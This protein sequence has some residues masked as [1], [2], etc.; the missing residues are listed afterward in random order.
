[1]FI[2]LNRKKAYKSLEIACIRFEQKRTEEKNRKK[3]KARKWK[4]VDVL[5]EW[6][7][8]EKEWLKKYE[9][10][11]K[12]NGKIWK[13]IK[14]ENIIVYINIKIK[15]GSWKNLKEKRKEIK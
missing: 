5:S 14:D 6:M 3:R 15:V 4:N 1:M 8:E 2:I 7:T 12:K 11:D 10:F 13:K 9:R